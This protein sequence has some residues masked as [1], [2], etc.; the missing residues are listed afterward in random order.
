MIL[1]HV[2][3]V[4]KQHIDR[5]SW[6]AISIMLLLHAGATWALLHYLGE[7]EL[8]SLV[9]YPY[10]YIVTTST[11]GYGDFSP[12]SEMGKWV[13][14]VLQIPFGLALFGAVLGKLGQTVSKVMRRNMTGEK[15]FQ[16]FTDHIIIFGWHPVRTKKMIDHILGDSKRVQRSILLCVTEDMLHPFSDY[17]Q[18]DFAKLT[19]MT[20][21]NE[22]TRVAISH[23]ARVIIDGE[24]DNQT[25]TTGLRI[26]GLVSAECHISAY[27][28]DET[29]MEML[30]DHCSNIEC[31]T[32]KTAEMLVRTMQDPGASRV[33]EEMLSTLYGDTQF[34]L[35]IP[36]AVNG[37][38]QFKSLFHYFKDVHAATIIALA[39][40]RIGDGMDLNPAND[41]VVK[42]GQILHYLAETRVLPNEVDWQ[43]I[44]TDA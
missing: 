35:A 4:I 31:T 38:T 11:V 29:K 23:A 9:N 3:K 19:S 20:D 5:V 34:S 18:V 26:S 21:K 36:A 17:E 7:S 1:R 33:Q 22:L 28:E 43:Q 10:Y 2:L 44:K 12:Q 16:H 42:E 37:H 6:M 41:I 24:D 13:V 15:D 27:F 14:S 32:S 40:N 25:F 39:D 30:R 8:T